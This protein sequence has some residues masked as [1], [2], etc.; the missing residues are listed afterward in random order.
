MQKADTILCVHPDSA[1]ID[2]MGRH[3]RSRP[4]PSVAGAE[5]RGLWSAEER[6]KTIAWRELRALR[7]ILESL[8]AARKVSDTS[9]LRGERCWVDNRAVVHI[10]RAMVTASDKLIPEFRQLRAK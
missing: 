8:P 6:A 1:D 2:R 7:L 5:L 9:P 10:V 3:R 4:G